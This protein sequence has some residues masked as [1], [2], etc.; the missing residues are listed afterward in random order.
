M[1]QREL[2]AEVA[3]TTGESLRT[4]QRRGFN[5][6][7]VLVDDDAESA[8]CQMPQI[9]DWDALELSRRAA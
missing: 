9:V 8:M 6:E 5:L 4:I 2:D 1:S 7:L 3:R